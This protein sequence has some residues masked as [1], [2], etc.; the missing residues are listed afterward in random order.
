MMVSGNKTKCM[1]TECTSGMMVGDF[2]E[3]IWTIKNMASGLTC[4]LMVES[5]MACGRMAI[6]MVR[7]RSC[8]QT[9]Q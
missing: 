1:G 3:T 4:G 9:C 5:I 7:E 8:Y 2:R 6:S